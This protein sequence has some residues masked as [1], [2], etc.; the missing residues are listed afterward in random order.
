MEIVCDMIR[1]NFLDLTVT[2]VV[3][4]PHFMLATT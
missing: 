3:I 2:Y 1:Y 4:Y